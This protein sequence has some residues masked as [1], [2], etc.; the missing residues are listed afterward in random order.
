MWA[1]VCL[2]IQMTFPVQDIGLCHPFTCKYGFG[3]CA[4]CLLGVSPTWIIMGWTQTNRRVAKN[5]NKIKNYFPVPCILLLLQKVES[6]CLELLLWI[7][8]IV[9]YL[10]V[11][12]IVV[13]SKLHSG[14]QRMLWACFSQLCTHGK[15]MLKKWAP[16]HPVFHPVSVSFNH[17]SHLSHVSLSF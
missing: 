3:F 2:Y 13:F 16:P 6:V 14:Y 10:R 9:R 5:P 15:L 8:M 4:F 12:K 1:H 17:L 11:G 7:R